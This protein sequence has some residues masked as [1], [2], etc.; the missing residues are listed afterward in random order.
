MLMK[1]CATNIQYGS[2]LNIRIAYETGMIERLNKHKAN[3]YDLILPM[4][5][6]AIQKGEDNAD[7]NWE[8]SMH[9]Q[10]IDAYLGVSINQ[11]SITVSL[12]TINGAAITNIK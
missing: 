11:I 4:A 5:W 10:K 6:A 3:W 9:T 7:T 1:I 8:I 2:W 12:Q